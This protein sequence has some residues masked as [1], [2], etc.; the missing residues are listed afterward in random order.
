M[1]SASSSILLACPSSSLPVIPSVSYDLP[2]VP[3]RC[4]CSCASGDVGCGAVPFLVPSGGSPLS[5]C[6]LDI[7]RRMPR[8]FAPIISSLSCLI[9][10]RLPLR[11]SAR[12]SSRFISLSMSVPAAVPWLLASRPAPSTRR[13]GR[14]DGA[15][16]VLSALLA[17]PSARHLIRAVRYWMATGFCACLVKLTPCLF[18]AP[19]PSSVP[20]ATRSLS[21]F[22]FL[23][24]S[25]RPSSPITRHGGR[26]GV[27]CL[28]C[29][30][31]F[32]LVRYCR[33]ISSC[34]LFVRVLWR[35]ASGVALLAWLSY[36]VSCRWGTG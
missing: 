21:Q 6:L 34:C 31:V 23:I 14:Y 4:R 28:G 9:A 16:A 17:Y 25:F 18:L 36:Y 10:C 13:A 26:G 8:R 24:A 5:P 29:L 27:L 2:P 32:R 19:C 1:V 7:C 20:P 22:D 35:R 15:V 33:L 12:S 11:V 3:P 30:L